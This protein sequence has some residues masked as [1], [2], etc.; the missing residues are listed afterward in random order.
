MKQVIK[1]YQ[2]AVWWMMV[3]D[4]ARKG[5]KEE[6]RHLELENQYRTEQG[7]PTVEDE[8]K[9]LAAQGRKLAAQR[10]EKEKP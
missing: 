4:E 8:L 2:E 7:L 3:V 9:E 1:S 6:Q 5:N 10:Q